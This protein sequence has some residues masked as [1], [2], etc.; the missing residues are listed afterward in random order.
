MTAPFTPADGEL[1]RARRFL[2]HIRRLKPGESITY[3]ELEEVG[4]C[5]RAGVLQAMLVT[6]AILEKN[7]ERSV[8]NEGNFGYVRLTADE[9]VAQM[10]ARA[11]KV[12][13]A[14]RRALR[15]GNSVQRLR[16][17]LSPGVAA[18]FDQYNASL[19]LADS[20]NS[21]SRKSFADLLE[22]TKPTALPPMS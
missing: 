15:I 22:A 3:R 4:N 8:R 17:E 20:I 1:G 13:R 19:L 6:K 9:H 7:G 5:D 10:G 11:K 18:Q 14:G 12:K 21:R 2:D 16:R